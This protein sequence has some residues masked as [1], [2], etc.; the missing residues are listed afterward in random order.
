V[1]SG[2]RIAIMRDGKVVQIGTAEQIVMHPADDYVAE[3]VAGISRLK[4]VH[5][6][7]VMQPIDAF[8]AANG[9]LP[10]D[11]PWVSTSETLS[12]IITLAISDER[13][14]RVVDGGVDVGII[15]RADLL[16]TVIE[17]TEVS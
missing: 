16:R 5:A 10:A 8:V 2:N 9:P 15:T 1:R 14:I 4:V 11:S 7:A 6:N 13:A 12:N 3:F 17:G